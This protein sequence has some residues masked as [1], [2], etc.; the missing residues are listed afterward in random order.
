MPVAI[1]APQQTSHP[2]RRFII[3][4]DLPAS[5]LKV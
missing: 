2:A 5:R 4:A 3:N 1:N